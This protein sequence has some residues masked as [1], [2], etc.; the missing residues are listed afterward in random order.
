MKEV[1]KVKQT[2][3]EIIDAKIDRF[4]KCKKYKKIKLTGCQHTIRTK[5]ENG[6]IRCTSC[7][8]KAIQQLKFNNENIY[9]TS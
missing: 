5:G 4:K 2:D 1:Y 3:A 6:I 7:K 8:T 9:R